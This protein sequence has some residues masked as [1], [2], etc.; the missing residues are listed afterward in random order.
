M[1][2]RTSLPH[3]PLWQVYFPF[4]CWKLWLAR[5]ECIFK[6][7]SCSQH[8]LI[9]SSVQAAT[10]FHFLAGTTKQPMVRVPQLIHWKAPPHPYLKLNTD[11]SALDNPGLARAG[12]VLR[13][14]QGQWISGF[15]ARVGLATN[16]MAE[17]DVVRQGLAMAWNAGVKLLQLELDSRM[18]LTWLTNKTM[19]YP[20]NMLPLICDCKNLLD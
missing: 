6:N 20:T 18:V 2:G 5:N 12:G 14:H 19:N 4:T 15:S 3:Q 17:L 10:E 1:V 8:R 9:Y 11:G 16:N 7:Q 13:D